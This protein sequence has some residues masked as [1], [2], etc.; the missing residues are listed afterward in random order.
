MTIKKIY[1]IPGM[2]L[3][4][5]VLLLTLG[6]SNQAFTHVQVDF[7]PLDELSDDDQL[8][9]CY[10]YGGGTHRDG[11]PLRSAGE[12]SYN[13]KTEE[14]DTC[15]TETSGCWS[16]VPTILQSNLAVRFS[17]LRLIFIEY[18]SLIPL[19][20]LFHSWKNFLA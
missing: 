6:R 9:F 14:D 5:L 15:K 19:Y 20:I 7:G 1:S 18:Q 16:K 17:S 2:V 3:L 12:D 11:L 13:N 4:A 8:W 10:H